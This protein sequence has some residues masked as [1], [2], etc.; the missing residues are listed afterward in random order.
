MSTQLIDHNDDL[1]RLKD[2]G[3]VLEFKFNLGY[4][5]VHRIPYFNSKKEI[6]YGILVF[7]LHMA[8]DKTMR[9]IEHTAYFVGEAPCD[10]NGQIL[11]SILNNSNKQQLFDN[12]IVDHY[13]SAKPQINNGK[14]KDHYEKVVTYVGLIS[15]H[16]KSVD[17][18]ITEKGNKIIESSDSSVF[19]YLDTNSNKPELSSLNNIFYEQK[20]GIICLGGTGSYLL[21][22]I[23][24]VP[25]K[26]IHIFDGDWFYNNNAFRAPGAPS[27]EELISPQKK[28]SYFR[29]IYSKMNNSIVE[30][31]YYISPENVNEL[32]NFDF[33]FLCVDKGEI[34]KKIVTHL[35]L[36]NISFID[37]GMGINKNGDSLGG[38]LRVTTSTPEKRN[39]VWEKN[40][41]PFIDDL[42]NEYNSNIQIAELN[43]LNATL[44]VIKWKK[45]LG[46]YQD[47]TSEFN[48]FYLLGANHFIN[49]DK[50]NES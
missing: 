50:K 4:L 28:T 22:L 33:I 30:H 6:K 21:D 35:E 12:F 19:N 36:K 5:L 11:S 32:D 8:G 46:Y 3:F 27:K 38:M 15:S 44:A 18:N 16:P 42:E 9:N 14:Y 49:E 41:I 40:R 29:R 7:R 20:I 26:E 47:S 23:C 31:D 10:R 13:F 43:C 37:M 39:H 25:V 2:E 1:K 24:K 45:L 17:N 34:R 48:P